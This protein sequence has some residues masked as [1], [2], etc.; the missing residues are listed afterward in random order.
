[1]QLRD[2]SPYSEDDWHRD[3]QAEAHGAHLRCPNC[4]RA[5]CFHPVGVPPSD[6]GKRK[7]RACRM[8][9]FSQEADGTPAYR[10]R[11][12]VHTCLAPIAPGHRCEHCG[13]AGPRAWHPACWRI[14]APAE[15]GVT[16]CPHCGAVFTA[17]HVIPWPVAAP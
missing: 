9:G 5:E 4:G 2:V 10:S 17:D 7:Y 14:V 8:C 13:T 11:M 1:M 16:S 6:G 15:V 3:R 12:V